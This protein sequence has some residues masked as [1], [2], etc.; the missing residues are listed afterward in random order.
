MGVAEEWEEMEEYTQQM[1]QMKR[2]VSNLTDALAVMKTEKTDTDCYS[3]SCTR[4]ID[5]YCK[6]CKTF[7]CTRCSKRECKTNERHELYD[8]EDMY[9]KCKT[10]YYGWKGGK[11]SAIGILSQRQKKLQDEIAVEIQQMAAASPDQLLKPE[12]AKIVSELPAKRKL[13]EDISKQV[14]EAEKSLT[15]YGGSVESLSQQEFIKVFDE[16]D[17]GD[18]LFQVTDLN[19][20]SISAGC[21]VISKKTCYDL[22]ITPSGDMLFA[23]NRAFHICNT[24]GE[25]LRSIATDEGDFTSIQYYKGRIYTLMKEPKGSNKRRV[26]VYDAKTYQEVVRWELPNF[27]YISMLAVSNDKVYVVDADAKKI[28]IYS[29]TGQAK[30]DFFHAAFRNPVYMCCCAPDGILLTDWSA[31][32]VYKIECSTDKIAWQFNISSPRGVYC[33]KKGMV[34][35]W[36]SKEKAIYIRSADG[37][38]LR[39]YNHERLVETGAEYISGMCMTDNKLF[40]A[41]CGKGVISIDVFIADSENKN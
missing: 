1:E 11:Q 5:W 24:N 28:K 25:V 40:G 3:E 41:A 18:S 16:F 15:S 21:N 12:L 17:F 39:R 23:S 32:I 13:L 7:L 26:V 38:Q 22:D 37:K 33:D 8:F 31:D 14:E 27:A 34:W 36:S 4:P 2:Q 20:V 30:P 9:E 10:K 29:L 6:L 19:K 35:V